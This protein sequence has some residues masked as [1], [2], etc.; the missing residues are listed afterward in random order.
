MKKLSILLSV[1][2]IFVLIAGLASADWKTADWKYNAGD[3]YGTDCIQAAIDDLDARLDAWGFTNATATVI[4][5]GSNTCDL[6]SAALPFKDI[7]LAGTITAN[8]AAGLSGTYTNG[9]TSTNV[10]VITGGI[11]TSI[12]STP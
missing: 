6:G 1:L 5:K 9:P 8:G 3:L 11:V 10:L 2:C 7:K 4:A 12:T